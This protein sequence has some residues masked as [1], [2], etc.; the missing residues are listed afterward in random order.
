MGWQEELRLLDAKLADGSLTPAQHRKMRDELLAAAS[1][2]GSTSPVAAPRR[3]TDPAMQETAVLPRIPVAG[4]PMPAGQVKPPPNAVGE[5]RP[6][7]KVVE[8]R[9]T[10]PL[11]NPDHKQPPNAAALLAGDR[12][13]TAP[14]PADQRATESMA[15]PP[16]GLSR[17]RSVLSPVAAHQPT[18]PYA[19]EAQRSWTDPPP[20]PDYAQDDHSPRRTG[21]TWLFLALGVLLAGGLLAG[22][23][24]LLSKDEPAASTAA[25]PPSAPAQSSEQLPPPPANLPLEQRLPEL[26]GTQNANNSTMPVDRGTELKLYAPETAN[27]FKQNGASEVVYRS[28]SDGTDGYLVMV[29]PAGSP[30]GAKN[31]ADELRKAAADTGFTQLNLGMPPG[32]SALAGSNTVGRM[33]ATWYTSDNLAVAVWVSQG[34]DKQ[35]FALGERLKGTLAKVEA[36]LPPD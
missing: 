7:P 26:P 29:V 31:I 18:R 6:A 13:T 3:E 25:P 12:P 1:G 24:W 4:Q 2:G 28:S 30:E 8:S 27:M 10:L 20:P 14:S 19:T 32:K 33:N 11:G 16:R 21:S 34:F 35:Q 5:A 36:A 22:G 9:P 17:G 15:V 23:V